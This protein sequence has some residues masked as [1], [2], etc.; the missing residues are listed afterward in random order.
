MTAD[1]VATLEAEDECVWFIEDFYS[2]EQGIQH[3]NKTGDI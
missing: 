1:R 2:I 3:N